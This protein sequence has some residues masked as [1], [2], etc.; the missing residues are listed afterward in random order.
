[1]EHSQKKGCNLPPFATIKEEKGSWQALKY[2]RTDTVK[3]TAFVPVS[4]ASFCQLGKRYGDFRA[5]A[6]EDSFDRR[7]FFCF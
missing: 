6:K 3:N 4:N 1:M 5:S 2:W 7:L